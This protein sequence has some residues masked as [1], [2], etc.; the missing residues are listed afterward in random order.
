M[1][2]RRDP[3]AAGVANAPREKSIRKLL[4][5][6]LDIIFSFL[7]YNKLMFERLFGKN[8][9]TNPQGPIPV[10]NPYIPSDPTALSQQNA[11]ISYFMNPNSDPSSNTTVTPDQR[12]LFL[13]RLKN[14][15]ISLDQEADFL[16]RIRSPLQ[17]P[18]V[19][20]AGVFAKISAGPRETQIFAVA[21]GYNATNWQNVTAAALQQFID[22][23]R[24]HQPDYRTPIGFKAFRKEFLAG[25]KP[26]AS[27]NQIDSYRIAMDSLERIIY[28]KR[29]E[30]YQQFED[31]RK[32]AT[33]PQTSSTDNATAQTPAQDTVTNNTQ[34]KPSPSTPAKP[35]PL[36]ISAIA[37]ERR[38]QLLSRVV[39]DGDPWYQAGEEYRLSSVNLLNAGLDPAYETTLDGKIVCLSKIFQLSSG[40]PAAIAYIPTEQGVKVRSYYQ[41]RSEGLW[42]YMP[43]YVHDQSSSSLE[44][45][46]KS[47]SESATTLP[48]G[49]QSVLCQIATAHPAERIT[50][51]NPDFLFSGTAKSYLSMQ[52]YRDA[53]NTGQLRGDFYKEVSHTPLNPDARLGNPRKGAPQL[54]SINADK[55]PDFS[56]PLSAFTTYSELIGEMS[57]YGFSSHDGQYNWLFGRDYRGRSWVA[58]IEAVSPLTDTGC[59]KEWL[60]ATDIQTPLYEFSQQ[61]DGYGDPTDTRKG[62][63]SMWNN[64]LSKIPIIEQFIAALEPRNQS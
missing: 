55:A 22:P 61:A 50:M 16:R 54:I 23:P 35:A 3:A 36:T 57:L 21:T 31:L 12:Q 59:R 4:H 38:E 19:G 7:C 56:K 20:P 37:P 43:D 27:E 46:G 52:S 41:D 63:T 8:K 2:E 11:I 32:L 47:Y 18:A 49:L 33:N 40:R 28:G 60:S 26:Q 9:N 34:P 1:E 30:Y 13:A 44:W 14:N 10:I 42:H 53:L 48:V 25:I 29:L 45:F 39:I 64:Y 6:Y 51:T 5:W 15:E 17:D 62:Y 58:Y 24:R